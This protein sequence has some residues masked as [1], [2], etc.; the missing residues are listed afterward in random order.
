M[1]AKV[2]ISRHTSDDDACIL[3]I[4]KKYENFNLAPTAVKFVNKEE[5]NLKV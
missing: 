4:M 3:V 2:S 5:I 1:R